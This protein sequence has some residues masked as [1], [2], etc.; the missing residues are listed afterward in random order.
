[1]DESDILLNGRSETQHE[2]H[3]LT[4]HFVHSIEKT[5][6]K[7]KI[8]WCFWGLELGRYRSNWQLSMRSN[9]QQIYIDLYPGNLLIGLILGSFD[10]SKIITMKISMLIW[11]SVFTISL[12][13]ILYIL[14]MLN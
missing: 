6:V 7:Y 10:I 9:I 12:S 1:M 11:M 2:K 13:V 5:T 14:C 4:P 3:C 8:Q